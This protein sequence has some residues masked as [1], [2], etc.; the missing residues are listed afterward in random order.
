MVLAFSSFSRWHKAYDHVRFINAKGMERIRINL[1]DDKTV[2]LPKEKLQ[3]KGDRDFFIDAIR[4]DHGGVFISPLTLNMNRDPGEAIKPTVRFSTPIID[5]RGVKIG[6]LVINMIAEGMLSW[7][8]QDSNQRNNATFELLNAEGYW[9][10]SVDPQNEWAFMYGKDQSFAR[11]HPKDWGQISA[12]E[13]GQFLGTE[14]LLTFDTINMP[15][16]GSPS[17]PNFWKL[18]SR[19]TNQEL[20]RFSWIHRR[21]FWMIAA[22]LLGLMALVSA[23]LA[24]AIRRSRQ[25][26]ALVRESEERFRAIFERSTIGKSLTSP[27]GKLLQIN[28]AFSDMLGYTIEEIRQ[29]NFAQ[30]THPDDVAAGLECLRILLAGEQTVYRFEKRYL[31]KSS[32][33][34]WVDL[35]TTLIHD[36]RG[37]PLYLITSIVDIT[38]RK[39]AEILLQDTLESL[40]KAVGTTIQVMVSAVETRDPYTSGHQTRSADLAR[41]IAMEIGLP[42]DKIDGIRMAGSIHDI[43]KL[44]IPAEI[45]S[46]PTK[47]TEIEFSL[48][49][50]HA[51]KGFEMLK[52][53]E[54]QWPLAEIVYQHHERMDGSGYPRNLKGD[55]ILIEA[56][57][58]TIA[59]V[60]EAMA[61]HRPYRPSRGIAATLE[62]I[63][64]NRGILYDSTA[65][66][67]CLRLFREKGFQL[68]ERDL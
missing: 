33:I 5:A 45:L 51:R 16:T 52:N 31:H 38:K 54:S 29:L 64:M 37:T 36:E 46:K 17:G 57:I 40:R 63:E 60:V 23:G 35:S 18:V 28:K 26:E 44:S 25:A 61:S 50:E 30:I 59:D 19:V 14:G 15:A 2:A 56:R 55:E 9:L 58:L 13:S 68:K 20:E 8:H 1:M 12:K 34:V 21:G 66:D 11:S 67:A 22:V 43:G 4:L 24:T 27:E 42:Q 7:L 6:V 62:E 41:A 65:A 49:Q 47:L 10:H 48:V 3:H 53:V 32:N 39:Q